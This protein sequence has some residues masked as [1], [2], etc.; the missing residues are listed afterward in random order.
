MVNRLRAS[1]AAP[2]P[3]LRPRPAALFDASSGELCCPAH[4]HVVLPRCCVL[5]SLSSLCRRTDPSQCPPVTVRIVRV[6]Q[7]S[8]VASGN[9]R[10]KQLAT[11]PFLLRLRGLMSGLALVE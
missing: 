10:S 11:T 5:V 9:S 6:P 8:C 7:G 4:V 1:Q 2:L 3:R